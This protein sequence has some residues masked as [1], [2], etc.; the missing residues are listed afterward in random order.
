MS[1]LI[2]TG[3]DE[4]GKSTVVRTEDLSGENRFNTLWRLDTLPPSIDRPATDGLYDMGL[5]RGEA[6]WMQVNHE[7]GTTTHMHRTDSL[8]FSTLL[9]GSIELLLDT[10]SVAITP[11]DNIVL[12]GVVHAW[13]VG[14]SGAV[15][16]ALAIGL[17][18]A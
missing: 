13:R 15:M 11:G 6:V 1:R 2:V 9:S 14:Q 8:S 12:P 10:E 4:D 17:G 7:A 5:S 3:N 18:P 16:S